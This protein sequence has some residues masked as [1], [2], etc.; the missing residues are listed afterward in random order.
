M[1]KLCFA[2]S[3]VLIA[4]FL[5]GQERKAKD[6]YKMPIPKNLEQCFQLLGETLSQKELDVIRTLPETSIHDHKEFVYGADFFHAWKIYDGSRLTDY[7]NKRGLVGS[8][9]IYETI[10]VSYHRYL[11]K[12]PIDLEGQI[13]KYQAKQKVESEAYMARTKQET[14]NGIY[15][16]KDMEDCF[17]QLNK[18]LK[19]KDIE[20]IKSLSSK[21]E[22]IKY[23]HGLGLWIRNNWGLW[24][25]SRLQVYLLQKKLKH[26]DD[27]SSLILE[28]YYDWL[29]GNHVE[30]KKFDGK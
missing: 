11:N 20:E 1:R 17:L 18:I 7:F 28:Y 15:I 25:G 24:S 14:L 19:E 12:L 22:M 16:P 23:H 30:W 5:L 2:F 6:I 3:I 13:K 21:K 10:L 27:M 4:P 29:H 9:E 8:E 26:P